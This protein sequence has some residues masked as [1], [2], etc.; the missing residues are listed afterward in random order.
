VEHISKY[1]S[2]RGTL[3]W[4]PLPPSSS[5]SEGGSPSSEQASNNNGSRV[6]HFAI[7]I[8][9]ASGGYSLLSPNLTLREVHEK[10]WRQNKPVEL[11]YLWKKTN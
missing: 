3:D 8:P 2:L 9:L 4:L 7:Y 11:Y 1:L 6:G 5:C 10:H